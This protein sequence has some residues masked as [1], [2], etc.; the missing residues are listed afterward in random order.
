[1]YVEVFPFVTDASD[2]S[3]VVGEL[4]YVKEEH[5]ELVTRDLDG[6]EQ[7]D[8]ASD[9]GWYMRVVREVDYFE[10]HDNSRPQ[11]VRAWVYH[12]G[13]EVLAGMGE[14]QLVK[15]GDWLNY[16]AQNGAAKHA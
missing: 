12:G 11:Q 8:P 6:L 10:G 7:Y 9:S 3:R 1:M 5:Y 4:V 13:P 15:D 2:G 14:A 16:Q